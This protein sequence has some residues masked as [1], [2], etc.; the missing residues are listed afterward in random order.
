MTARILEAVLNFSEGRNLAV[1]ERIVDAMADAGATVLDWSADPDH[2][3]SVVTLVGEPSLVEE[4]AV[5]GVRTAVELIDLRV[6]R[7]VHPRIG[8]A[9]VVPFVPLAGLGMEEARQSARRVG[10]RLADEVGVPVF[11]YAAASEPPG[12]GLAELRRG[13][14]EALADAWPPGRV[15]DELPPDWPHGG[16]HPT[17]GACCVGARRVLLAWNVNVAGMSRSDAARVARAIR[18][19]AGG[20]PGLRALALDLPSRGLVQISMNLEN[21]ASTS[22]LA[23]YA[24]IEKLVGERGGRIVET[25]VIGMMPDELVFSAAADR[26][27]FVGLSPQRMLSRRLLEYLTTRG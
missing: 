20:F 14:F 19:T 18:E 9:D 12:R 23:V 7:G 8:A 26:L 22:P 2:N 10:R 1:V 21:V 15:P 3:R 13:G 16:A 27:S 24:R 11:Y 17:G 6:H 4:A 5:V 25:E